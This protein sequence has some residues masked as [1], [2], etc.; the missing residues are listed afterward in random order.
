MTTATVRIGTGS[1]PLAPGLHGEERKYRILSI[2]GGG[3]RGIIP[4]R[5]L[6]EIEKITNRKIHELFDCI[7]GTSTG[8]ILAL[9]LT[10]S[11]E[12]GSPYTAEE[13]CNMYTREHG[14]IFKKATSAATAANP[15]PFEQIHN[16]KYCDPTQ[17]FT[18]KF[19]GRKQ[20]DNGPKVLISMNTVTAVEDRLRALIATLAGV[21]AQKEVHFAV[22][23]NK[24]V[25]LKSCCIPG[26]N[27]ESFARLK[28][29]DSSQLL[30]QVDPGP[31]CARV[32]SAAPTYFPVVQIGKTSF[33]DGGVL[34]NN[35]TILCVAEAVT[36]EKK[37]DEDLLVV[38]LGTGSCLEQD[39]TDF[40][41][42]MLNGNDSEEA[43]LKTQING[44]K[45]YQER[46]RALAQQGVGTDTID[47][48]V[49]KTVKRRYYRFQHQFERAADCGLDDCSKVNTYIKIGDDLVQDSL[50]DLEDVCMRLDPTCEQRVIER[51]ANRRKI[52]ALTLV[53][54]ITLMFLCILLAE[55]RESR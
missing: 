11:R 41:L 44:G 31:L 37:Q 6:M 13:L 48:E 30:N 9:G 40:L 50:D 43:C 12:G 20:Q 7:G 2:D 22:F 3:I 54:S 28:I 35:P 26:N 4:C 42:N 51:R 29:N 17:F 52:D 36:T 34:Q 49:R 10:M 16:P 15:G 5:V 14:E 19:E 18:N 45:D 38:S 24:K 53:G 47:E 46:F 39:G 25:E 21:P 33:V 27:L 23:N 1:A 55:S 8:G 32:T